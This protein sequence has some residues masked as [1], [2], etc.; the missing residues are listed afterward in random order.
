M[1]AIFLTISVIYAEKWPLRLGKEVKTKLQ[2]VKMFHH[3]Q[4]YAGNGNTKTGISYGC[5]S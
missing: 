3:L 1:T 5:G 2:D 4:S